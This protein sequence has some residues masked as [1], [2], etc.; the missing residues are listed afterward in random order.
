M[1]GPDKIQVHGP[2]LLPKSSTGVICIE[3][4][5]ETDLATAGTWP[6]LD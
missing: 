3:G 4:G 1:S 5:P 2:A 6:I